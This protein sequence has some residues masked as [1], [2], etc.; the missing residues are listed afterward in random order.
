MRILKIYEYE[1]EVIL[2]DYG[3]CNIL[4]KPLNSESKDWAK[5]FYD[6]VICRFYGK[7]RYHKRKLV[8]GTTVTHKFD[9]EFKNADRYSGY[10][11]CKAIRAGITE[12]ELHLRVLGLFVSQVLDSG[13]R[14]IMSFDFITKS[15]TCEVIGGINP[16]VKYI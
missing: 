7:S 2:I 3:K 8:D 5:K 11:S 9:R 14:F 4:C 16:N 10:A 15:N 13:N 12:G 6:A 1:F